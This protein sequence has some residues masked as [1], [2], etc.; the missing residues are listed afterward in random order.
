FSKFMTK[1]YPFDDE[2]ASNFDDIQAYWNYS[3]GATKELGMLAIRLFSICINSASCERLFSTMG[4]FQNSR[5]TR[6]P[7]EKV[8]SMAQMRAEIKYKR[9]IEAAKSLEQN[10]L[11]NINTMFGS[12]DRKHKQINSDKLV[13]QGSSNVEQE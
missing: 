5:R 7:I 12:D 8:F 11:S 13:E 6:L 9:T 2:T 1:D 4:F 10:I 3:A